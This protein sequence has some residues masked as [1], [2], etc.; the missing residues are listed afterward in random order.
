VIGASGARD[1]ANRYFLDGV[2]FLDFETNSYAFAPSVDS[3][4]EVKVETNT[5]SALYGAA[6]GAQVDLVTR[7]GGTNYHGTLWQFN[8]NDFFSQTRDVIAGRTLKPLRLNR[9]QYGV[10]LG[11]PTTIPNRFSPES[12]SFFFLNWERGNLR[13]G[14]ADELFLTPPTAMRQGDFRSLT[15]ARTGEPIAL[16]DPLGVGI[17]GNRIPAALLSQPSLAFLGFV[18]QPNTLEGPYNYRARDRKG[19]ARQDNYLGRLDHNLR[20]NNLITARYVFNETD[21]QNAPLWGN[22]ERQNRAR[23]QNLLMQ[24]TRTVSA[25]RI[26]QF[27]FGWNR[28]SDRERFATTGN[29]A[30]DV[31]GA[32][33]IPGLSRRPLDY[34]PP[35]VTIDGPDGVFDVFGLPRSSGPRNRENRS[36]QVSNV[37]AWQQRRHM[38]RAGGDWILKREDIRLARNPRGTFAFDGRYTGSALAD[39]MLGYVSTAEAAPTPTE[40]KLESR[41]FS[42][43]VQDDWR[44]QPDLTLSFGLRYDRLPAFHQR[45]GRAVNIEQDGF[46]LTEL[47]EASESRFGRRMVDTSPTN[48]GPRFGLAW[49][50][51]AVPNLVL[52]AGYGFYFTPARPGVAFRMAEGAQENRAVAVQGALTGVPDLRLENPFA[53]AAEGLNLAVSV[54]PYIRD[55]YTQHWNFSIQRRVLFDILLDAAYAGTKGTRLP[56]TLDDINRPVDAVDPRQPGV[57]PLDARRANP[58]FAR[59]VLG[60]KSIGTSSFHSFQ[61]AASRSSTF[62]L[63]LVL[64]YT[65]SKCM[66]GPGDA[67]AML[68]G[69]A[70]VGRPQDL[71]NLQADRSLCGFDVSHR[72]SGSAIYETSFRTGPALF[73]W[74]FDGWR[75]A[76]I[77]TAASGMPAPVFSNLDTTG[78]GLPSRP[79]RLAGQTGDL[80]ARDRTW[81]RWFNVEAFAAPDFGRFGTAPRTGAVRLPGVLNLD[82]AFARAFNLAD[83]RRLELRAEIFNVTNHFNP[84]PGALDLNLQSQTFGSVGRGVQGVTTRVIQLAGKVYF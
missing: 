48:F 4:S 44:V 58:A 56:V 43:F 27:R 52:R 29:P 63:E 53:G 34:G 45:D 26:N 51:T 77:P 5:Y 18:P 83:A 7:T 54:D 16:Q 49:A 60:E 13:Q 47:V 69:G 22:D 46:R 67:G 6:H 9:N 50:P 32:M 82:L 3:L 64:A 31:A 25:T 36:F 59:A 20:S 65:W 84:Q 71:Y 70:Y 42:A 41:W 38:I 40:A 79:D 35:A 12:T 28:L 81:Q 2:E 30:F 8:R 15:N 37:L 24:Y 1:S 61:A 78:T 33:G 73:K 55:A 23:G 10:N 62:G 76:A 72:L 68:D 14:E 80:A 57:A 11:G 75:I 21:E 66:S 74:L 39:F 17:E 19:R